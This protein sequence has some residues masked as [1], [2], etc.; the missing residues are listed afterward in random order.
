MFGQHWR[1]FSEFEARRSSA[2]N[3]CNYKERKISRPNPCECHCYT[4]HDTTCQWINHLL[5][6]MEMTDMLV[7]M[8]FRRWSHPSCPCLEIFEVVMYTHA[9][10]R[11]S[12]DSTLDSICK[13]QAVTKNGLMLIEYARISVIKFEFLKA[14]E[15][16]IYSAGHHLLIALCLH[17]SML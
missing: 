4:K 17:C 1:T 12:L 10:V 15:F 7:R 9:F 3:L 16:S 6:V 2:A 8:I 13:L 5:N 14:D 11:F